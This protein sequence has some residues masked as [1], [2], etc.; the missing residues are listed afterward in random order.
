M[1]LFVF[2]RRNSALKIFAYII[3]CREVINSVLENCREES[4][5][6]K[7]C[8]EVINTLLKIGQEKSRTKFFC[9]EIINTLPEESRIKHM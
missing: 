7:F 3:F 4:R 5:I 8:H 6:K 1:K 2:S 9:R